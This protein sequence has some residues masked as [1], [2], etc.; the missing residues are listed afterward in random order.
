[1]KIDRFIEEVEK[2]GI[3]INEDLLNK[4]EI[5]YQFLTEYNSHTN[6]TAITEKD[7]VYLKHFYDSLTIKNAV[8]LNNIQTLIDIGSGAG[9][10]GV[11]LKIFFPHIS[12]TILDSNGKKTLFISQLVE[13]LDLK[14]IKVINM[15]AE[16][17]AIEET[18]RYDLCVSRAVAYVDIISELSLPFIKEDGKV[19]L[20]KGSVT[21]EL[22]IL[23]K[24]SN[25]LNINDFKVIKFNLP[26]IE[27]ERNL[28]IIT[29]KAKTTKILSYNQI[30]K[31]NKK[32]NPK[33]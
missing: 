25:E 18:N 27:D 13:K 20:M 19:V 9:F 2:L 23:E 8:D 28:I 32:W 7:D 17:F 30:L 29:K 33:V 3:N 22:N 14:D 21:T 6:L 26:V 4:L 10:P 16:D 11:V 1:M 5:Y 12:T 15:R 24:H 31:R